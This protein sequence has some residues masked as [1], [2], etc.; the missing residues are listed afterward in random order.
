MC[1]LN[2]GFLRVPYEQIDESHGTCHSFKSFTL[3]H[4]SVILLRPGPGG[5]TTPEATRLYIDATQSISQ[6]WG[7]KEFRNSEN[8]S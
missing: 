8:K 2:I 1:V 5:V 4:V 3:R 7:R 6:I